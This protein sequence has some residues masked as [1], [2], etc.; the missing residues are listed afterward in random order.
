VQKWSRSEG[1]SSPKLISDGSH[2]RR[3]KLEASEQR[4]YGRQRQVDQVC[5]WCNE[6]WTMSPH[7]HCGE[8]HRKN[9]KEMIVH[10]PAGVGKR[11]LA[12]SIRPLVKANRGWFVSGTLE[13][14]NINGEKP[15]INVN[16]QQ[17]PLQS[18]MYQVV[19]D[20][21]NGMNDAAWNEL[22]TGSTRELNLQ[23]TTDSE[24]ETLL[25]MRR[26][27]AQTCILEDTRL[28]KLDCGSIDDSNPHLM[29]ATHLKRFVSATVFGG[30][31]LLA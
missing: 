5:A 2:R 24:W 27:G 9:G 4:L 13:P 3:L 1:I 11:A 18:A 23:G 22:V 31:L 20:L 10:G 26:R 25:G 15:N 6:Q 29:T 16:Q 8:Q 14:S 21:V 12:R 30:S 7:F 17:Q 28:L 19:G